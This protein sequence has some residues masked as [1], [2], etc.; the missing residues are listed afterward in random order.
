VFHDPHHYL[1]HL[2]GG[3][4]LPYQSLTAFFVRVAGRQLLFGTIDIPDDIDN[5]LVSAVDLPCPFSLLNVAWLLDMAEATELAEIVVLRIV[6]VKV[7]VRAFADR[8]PLLDVLAQVESNRDDVVARLIVQMKM[9]ITV[10]GGK[11]A[12]HFEALRIG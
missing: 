5:A 9:R 11:T 4:V 12:E 6:L 3:E 8:I 1:K 2:T 7:K 10:T